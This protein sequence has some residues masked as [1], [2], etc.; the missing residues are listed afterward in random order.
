MNPLLQRGGLP[1][2]DQITPELVGPAM[3]QLLTEAD[4]ALDAVTAPDFAADWNAVASVLDVATERL[5]RAWS[6]V[7]HLNSVAD[8]PALRAAYNASLPKVTAFWTRLGSDERLYAKYKAM[9]ESMLDTEQCQARKNALRD[10]V[11]GGAELTGADKERFAAIQER[12]AE[13]SQKFSENALD[14]TDKFSLVVS[15]EELAGVPEDLLHNTREAAKAAQCDG[16]KL[17]LKLPCYLPV[18]QFADSARAARTDVPRL[19]HPRRRIRRRRNCATTTTP[20]LIRE[21]L[22]L[23]QEEAR[24]LGFANFAELS[25]A[26][27][28][29][30]SPRAVID[31][32]HDLAAR[33]RPF[34]LQDLADLRAFAAAELHIADPQ[35]WDWAYIGE[36]LKHAR[37][38]FSEQE[39][40]QYFTLPKVLAGLFKIVETLFDVAIRPDE[41]PVW[42]ADVSFY[43]HRTRRDRPGRAVLP[44]YHGPRRQAG[45]R[46]DG[47]CPHP[48]AAPRQ[49]A[50]CRR[51]WRTWSAISPRA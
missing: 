29:A 15:A 22:A 6:A 34:A 37:Y 49:P 10:F 51:R 16:H 8:T 32:L 25:L 2:F 19:C 14:A 26:A 13:L 17:S 50:A 3:L 20:A 24:L 39:V 43:P 23:R 28:M 18:M 35:A 42:H 1:P 36:K 4:A 31:F 40:K 47:R 30:A 7:S 41:A 38:A 44:R 11:L 5:G 21:I 46:L 27:K 33:A 45:R 9:P 48:L 12:Q